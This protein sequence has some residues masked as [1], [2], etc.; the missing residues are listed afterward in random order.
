M[1]ELLSQPASKPSESGLSCPCRKQVNVPGQLSS[2]SCWNC[3]DPSCRKRLPASAH[4]NTDIWRGRLAREPERKE[5]QRGETGGNKTKVSCNA[6]PVF[7]SGGTQLINPHIGWVQRFHGRC[8]RFP[9]EKVQ[10]DR[11]K[12]FKFLLCL[13]F[14]ATSSSFLPILQ[15]T[16]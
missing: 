2:S 6:I 3:C 9:Q 12:G 10:E 14:L 1:H 8:M 15:R 11:S 5:W 4:S 13:L 16:F 7:S